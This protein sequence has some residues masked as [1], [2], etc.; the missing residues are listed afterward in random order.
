MYKFFALLDRMKW[1]NRWGLMKNSYAENLK[2]HSFQVAV[3]SHALCILSNEYFGTSLFPEKAAEIALFHD[4]SEIITGDMPTPVKYANEE[5]KTNYKNIEAAATEKIVA[6]LPEEI[7]KYYYPVT[8]GENTPEWRYVKAADTLSAYIKCVNEV[9]VGNKDFESAK[10]NTEA[11][12]KKAAESLPALALFLKDYLPA[13]EM[14]I[15]GLS[16]N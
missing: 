13:Y 2:E 10:K 3:L 1:I 9:S 16:L 7:R 6:L 8:D 5:L 4:I 15:D 12:L 14:P 11:K